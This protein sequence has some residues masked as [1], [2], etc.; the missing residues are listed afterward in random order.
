M[1]NCERQADL[2]AFS[3]IG[4]SHGLVSSLEKI[5]VHSGHAHDRP[6]WHHFSIRQRIDYMG[7]CESDRR[8][9]ARHDR[10]LRRSIA[11]FIIGLLSTGYLGYAINFGKMGRTLNSH[12]LQTVLTKEIEHNPDNP[13]LYTMLASLHYENHAYEKAIANYTKAIDLAPFNTEAL[14]NLAWLFATCERQEYRNSK[15]ALRLAKQAAALSPEPHVLDTLAESY[16][17]NGFYAE[18]IV[19]ITEALAKNP[20][21]RQYYESQLKKFEKKVRSDESLNGKQ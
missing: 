3:L 19:A 17:I 12:F 16:F 11:V 20:K 5:A 10:K 14:N 8:W 2:Y 6:S 1:R 9:I 4:N 21:D 18:A 13:R 7:K 15:R